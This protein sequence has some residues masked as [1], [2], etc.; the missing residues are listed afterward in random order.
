M[1]KVFLHVDMDAFYA[2][3]EQLDHPEL[4]GKRG[5]I[6]A[7]SYEARK[8]GIHSAMPSRQ[9]AKLCPHAVFMPVNGKRYYEM[10]QQVF[11]VFEQFTP[12]IEPLSID[13]AFLDVTGAQR[14]FGSGEE[15]AAKIKKEVK[16]KTG[17]TASVGV[18]KNK[19][20]AK[21]ASDLEK[22]DGLTVVPRSKKEIVAFLAP[23]H[24][25]RIWGVGK[26]TQKHLEASAIRTVG[27]IQKTPLEILI[28]LIGKNSAEHLY[29]LA[30]GEDFR[31]IELERE[32][33]SCSR[34]YTFSEDCTSKEE[35]EQVLLDLVDD[36]GVHLRKM[37][38]YASVAHRKLRWQ[39]FKTITRQRPF[40]HPCCDDFALRK[41][42]LELFRVQDL[43]K[44]VRLIGFG[45]SRLIDHPYK[46]EQLNLFDDGS[47]REKK[48]EKLSKAVDAIKGKL[49]KKA[50]RRGSA[51]E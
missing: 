37:E 28:G 25:G 29:A 12:F 9:A 6:S 5:V 4:R 50:I 13:E 23:L 17:L 10:S 19:F 7:A 36:V 44:P 24:V 15:I 42:A 40:V 35:L 8:F 31:D 41:I 22:P 3:V 1:N 33:K 27:D 11:E 16:K 21:I 47:Q 32:E 46:N 26:V 20:L 14:M 30:H 51:G 39:G 18:A 38:K 45:V 49:G 43:I 34:E 48:Q 2:S